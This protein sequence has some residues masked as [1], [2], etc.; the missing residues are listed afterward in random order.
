MA[1]NGPRIA[2]NASPPR[3]TVDS[4]CRVRKS[5]LRKIWAV[6]GAGWL[7]LRICQ[8]AGPP[9]ADNGDI[10][11]AHGHRDCRKGPWRPRG[12]DVGMHVVE[13]I[14]LSRSCD[15]GLFMARYDPFRRTQKK[16]APG[17][18]GRPLGGGIRSF[19][20]GVGASGRGGLTALAA[21]DAAHHERAGNAQGIGGRLGDDDD[22]D[23]DS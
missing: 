13:I 14:V 22:A 10:E 12:G 18:R 9:G 5:H 7:G 3:R 1:R 6:Y 20:A 16:D 19:G 15:L 4:T 8:A 11:T 23:A 17:L 2:C 21:C